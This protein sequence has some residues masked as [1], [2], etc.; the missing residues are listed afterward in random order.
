MPLTQEDKQEIRDIFRAEIKAFF[1][2]R[3]KPEAAVDRRLAR[4][5]G[6]DS[7]RLALEARLKEREDSRN[8]WK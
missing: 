2:E 7:M 4:S 6:I 1:E 5:A 3:D 8:R